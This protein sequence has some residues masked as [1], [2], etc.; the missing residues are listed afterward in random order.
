MFPR[1]HRRRLHPRRQ[2][3]LPRSTATK[4]L[5][6]P[7]HNESSG[8]TT[9]DRTTGI[10]ATTAAISAAKE[11]MVDVPT[12]SSTATVDAIVETADAAVTAIN[13]TSSSRQRQSLQTP[14]R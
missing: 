14:R 1:P 7:P 8:G 12:N 4:T 2:K 9:I 11:K 13:S 5:S 6:K 3:P 10:S